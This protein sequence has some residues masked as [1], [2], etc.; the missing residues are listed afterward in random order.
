VSDEK[1][2]VGRPARTTPLSGIKLM[3][4]PALKALVDQAAE[5]A[6]LSTQEWIRRALMR[7]LAAP[8]PTDPK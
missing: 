4:E 7:A 2:P 1:R 3:L 5:K 6:G 8:L